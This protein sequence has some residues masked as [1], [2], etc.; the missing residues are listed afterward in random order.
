M[1]SEGFIQFGIGSRFTVP[2]RRER[3]SYLLLLKVMFYGFY[4]GKSPVIKPA[5][6][7]YVSFCPTTEEANPKGA[8][9]YHAASFFYPV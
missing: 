4:H 2:K 7:E 1:T 8:N 5:F 6:G 3:Y 9:I